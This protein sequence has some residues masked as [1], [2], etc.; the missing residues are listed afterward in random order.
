MRN[1]LIVH[2][3]PGTKARETHQAAIA[4]L[5]DWCSLGLGHL[6]SDDLR[7]L[8]GAVAIASRFN[9]GLELEP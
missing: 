5:G 2:E 4:I 1:A 7:T 9:G 6:T 3:P 8:N